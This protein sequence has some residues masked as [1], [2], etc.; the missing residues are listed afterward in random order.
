[1]TSHYATK[2]EWDTTWTLITGLWPKWEPTE[3]Q[4]QLWED[5]LRP[6]H[7]PEL[8]KAV[9]RCAVESRWREPSISSIAAVRASMPHTN[10][11]SYAGPPYTMDQARQEIADM[12]Q[13]FEAGEPGFGGVAGG[14]IEE[15]G[16]TREFLDGRL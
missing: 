11:H 10:T 12:R 5:E 2:D 13:Y 15:I 1:M 3:Q 16:D 4:R 14:M 6:R 8:R 9:K 7:Q